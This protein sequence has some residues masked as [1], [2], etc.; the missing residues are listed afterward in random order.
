[1][2]AVTEQ[3][4][5]VVAVGNELLN[6]SPGAI[7]DRVSPFDDII[8][9]L[10]RDVAIIHH[11]ASLKDREVYE[12]VHAAVGKLIHIGREIRGLQGRF[13]L[14]ET[15]CVTPVIEHEDARFVQG[16]SSFHRVLPL[17]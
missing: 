8:S 14:I 6:V 1:M 10:L 15:G 3:L 5:W 9:P 17:W 2:A 16:V 13:K 12:G 11:H 4:Q 7:P